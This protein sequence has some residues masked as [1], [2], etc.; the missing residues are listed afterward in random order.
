M[1]K[2]IATVIAMFIAMVAFS[3]PALATGGGNTPAD[4]KKVEFCHATGNATKPYVKIETSVAAFYNAG[5]IDHKG[6][7]WNTFSY[8]EKDGDVVTVPA[9]GDTSLLAF[10][11]CQKPA[12]DTKIAKPDVV[13]NDLCGTAN[14]V[15][16]VAPGTGYTVGP[17]V[18][19]GANQSIT[20][21]ANNGFV[22][23]DGTKSVRF[24]KPAFTNE[25]C[26]LPE[27]G[28]AVVNVLGGI[29]VLGLIVAGALYLL[30][31]RRV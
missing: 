21:T 25:D 26:D 7:I 3:A 17:V 13:F 11:D 16:T 27:T 8:T 4:N 29:V 2:I 19:E 24:V 1:K 28:G 5:H 20:V 10:E 9:Q 15:F 31:R 23:T 12:T 18:Q 30:R 6:D 14:D 22:F